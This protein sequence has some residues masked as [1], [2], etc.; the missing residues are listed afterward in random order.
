VI[1]MEVPLDPNQPYHSDAVEGA[2]ILK[3][4][5]AKALI[6]SR[7]PSRAPQ[8]GRRP[9]EGRRPSEARS[10]EKPRSDN[11]FPKKKFRSPAP[12]KND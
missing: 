10:G 8:R 1:K 7:G 2:R 5:Q 4:G 11:R 9:Q 3:P 6:E 12:K